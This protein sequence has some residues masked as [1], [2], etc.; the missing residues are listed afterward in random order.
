MVG[1]PSSL[2]FAWAR[3]ARKGCSCTTIRGRRSA[4]YRLTAA[5]S[6]KAVRAVATSSNPVGATSTP[7]NASYLMVRSSSPAALYTRRLTAVGLL[8]FRRS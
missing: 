6:G 1:S 2:A 8:G 5:I 3:C 7:S 4:S